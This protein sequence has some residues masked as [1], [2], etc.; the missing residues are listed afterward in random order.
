MT[1]NYLGLRVRPKVVQQSGQPARVDG[2][3]D[4]R[5]DSGLARLIY[6]TR[7]VSTSDCYVSVAQCHI[8]SYEGETKTI[9]CG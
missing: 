5:I 4:L 8:H 6:R 1:G 2:M 9:A 7:D 3:R